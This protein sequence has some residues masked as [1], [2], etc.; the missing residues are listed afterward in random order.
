[1]EEGCWPDWQLLDVVTP[2]TAGR[3]QRQGLAAGH[4]PAGQAVGRS[5]GHVGDYGGL[6][7][8]IVGGAG[9]P[10]HWRKWRCWTDVVTDTSIYSCVSNDKT[11]V[12]CGSR[13]TGGRCTRNNEI[14]KLIQ[15]YR[16]I[17]RMPKYQ[18]PQTF[19]VQTPLEPNLRQ[20][21]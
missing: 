5:H 13:G 1:M 14:L 17:K 15:D 18:Y 19:Q 7:R 9:E 12:K 11:L 21:Y 2:A 4:I 16:G 10:T 6:V 20:T 8:R 3:W